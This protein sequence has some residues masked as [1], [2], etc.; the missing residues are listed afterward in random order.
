MTVKDIIYVASAITEG[1]NP[2][3]LLKFTVSPYP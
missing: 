1:E 3:N 2:Y